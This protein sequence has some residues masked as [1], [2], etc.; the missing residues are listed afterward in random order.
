MSRV[1]NRSMQLSILMVLFLVAAAVSAKSTH[2][3]ADPVTLGD[4]TIDLGAT[5][6]AAFKTT[7][8]TLAKEN[9]A[10]YLGKL[11]YKG[12]DVQVRISV[13][14]NVLTMKLDSVTATGC[15]DNCEDLGEEP[16]L[17]WLVSLRRSITV[18]LTKRIR[19]SLQ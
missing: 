6:E 16:V 2:P 7:P 4:R 8:W 17:R 10:S 11:S 13:V 3:Y 5:L 19:D 9:D 15:G 1:I 18:E 14:D 12:F